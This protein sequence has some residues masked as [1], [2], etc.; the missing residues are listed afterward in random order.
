MKKSMIFTAFCC[1]AF[2]SNAQEKEITNSSTIEVN[3]LNETSRE[4][5]IVKNGVEVFYSSKEVSGN[6]LLNIHFVNTSESTVTF[7]W[8]VIKA[9]EVFKSLKTVTLKPGE[10][11]DQN[12]VLEMKGNSSLN[13][14][15]IQLFIK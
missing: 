4:L 15:S 14:Y 8:S 11:I 7:N 13:D 12:A 3:S 2:M 5:I 9:G 1:L 6:T 10:S